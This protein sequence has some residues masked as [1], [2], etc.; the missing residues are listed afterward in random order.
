MK[1]FMLLI[2]NERDAKASLSADE[3]LAF[4][5]KCESYIGVLKT[6]GKLTSVLIW[7]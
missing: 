1:E 3:H 6:A 5:K 2:R 4:I 7:M